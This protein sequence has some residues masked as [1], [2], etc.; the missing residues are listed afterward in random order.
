MR[1]YLD[2]LQ[3]ILDK[4]ESHDDRTGTGTLSLFGEQ[5]KI[6]LAEGFPLLT[7]KKVGFRWVAEELF[8]FLSGDTFE[9][10][11]RNNGVDIWKEWA[12]KEK[13]LKFGRAEGELGPVYGHAWRNFGADR[14]GGER[15]YDAAHRRTLNTGFDSNGIDQIRVLQSGIENDPN[16]RRLIV[17]G[18]HP[19]EARTVALPP[20]HT[21]WQVK[22]HN[23]GTVDEAISLHLYARSIDSFLGLP[24]NIASYAL[25]ANLLAHVNGCGVRDLIISFGDVHLY[26]NHIEQAK[27]QL[28]REPRP[29]PTLALA[30]SLESG[31]FEAL[32]NFRADHC[33]IRGYDP[34]PKIEAEVAV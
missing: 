25:L 34:H 27:L 22:V 6:N 9:P 8:W 29:L 12:T 32:M 2:L 13:C 28:T 23:Q 17:T 16:S 11:L 7:T 10:N 4:G 19:G 3:K 26:K 5:L 14:K 21:L 18:W 24:F 31:G 15:R 33:E 1:S 30:T 20:C